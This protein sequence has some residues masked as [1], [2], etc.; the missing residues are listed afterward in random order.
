MNLLL[1]EFDMKLTPLNATMGFDDEKN[2][3]LCESLLF[4]FYSAL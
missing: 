4:F 1:D 2:H 3:F